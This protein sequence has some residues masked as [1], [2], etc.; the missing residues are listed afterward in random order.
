MSSAGRT[1]TGVEVPADVTQRGATS[2]PQRWFRQLIDEHEL[3][4]AQRRIAHYVAEHMEETSY[5]SV[6]EM[7]A[8]VGV[9]QPSVTRFAVALGFNGYPEFRQE[10]RE[11]MLQSRQRD[12]GAEPEVGSELQDAVRAEIR[13]L[14]SLAEALADPSSVYALASALAASDPLLVVGARVGAPLAQFFAHFAAK[15]L[16]DVRLYESADSATEEALMR[17]RRAGATWVLG[18][19]MPRYPR[20]LLTCLGRARSAGLKVGVIA[21]RRS[22]KLSG[23]ADVVLSASVGSRLV[24]DSQAAPMVL[25]TVLLQAICDV[26]PADA[27]SRLEEFDQFAAERRLFAE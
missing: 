25:T 9:S 3:S 12:S 11:Q 14:E 13:N 8:K 27:E 26:M 24:F 4:P 20:E 7:G 23:V 10:V 21:D 17:G 5:A 1:V 2:D 19:A 22:P 15:V 16:P 6:V 18:I